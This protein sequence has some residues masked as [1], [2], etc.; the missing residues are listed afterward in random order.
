[1]ATIRDTGFSYFD[2]ASI[3]ETFFSILND[4]V[5][6]LPTGTYESPMTPLVSGIS[7]GFVLRLVNQQITELL[8]MDLSN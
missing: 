3:Q 2:V 7:L 4:Q 1:M 8:I 6:T 5:I